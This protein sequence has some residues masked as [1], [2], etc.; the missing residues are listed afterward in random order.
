[1]KVCTDSCLFGGWVGDYLNKNKLQPSGILD[2]GSGTGL[3]A[4]MLAQ[5]TTSPIEAIEIDKNSYDQSLRNIFTSKFNKSI[6]IFHGDMFTFKYPRK[7]EMIVCNPP[8][9]IDQLK[10][11]GVS[12]SKA[13]H[14][15]AGNFKKIFKLADANLKEHGV[16]AIMVMHDDLEKIISWAGEKDFFP[17]KIARI[18]HSPA[19]E[20]SR[21]FILFKKEESKFDYENI[22]IR[23]KEN[24][25]TSA[26]NNLLGDFYL[27]QV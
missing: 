17:S 4:L 26:F 21:V 19:H 16:L 11:E 25:Y 1:M 23:N 20:F 22:C 14:N 2:A 10:S 6:K 15:I 13:M 24:K 7:Y 3:L 18:K 12:K 8:F 9:F 5:K 27:G